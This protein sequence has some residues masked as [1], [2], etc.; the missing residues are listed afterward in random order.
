MTLLHLGHLDQSVEQHAPRAVYA[1]V[2]I[3]PPAASASDDHP[4][5]AQRTEVVADGA[6]RY[7]ERTR[8]LPYAA[9]AVDKTKYGKAAPIA[10]SL[11]D[12]HEVVDAHDRFLSIVSRNRKIR[13]ATAAPGYSRARARLSV[14]WPPTG[15]HTACAGLPG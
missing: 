15:P 7:P 8:H 4:C 10:E 1:L 13:V 3:A 2:E 14:R 5:E 11:S 6:G 12:S 9:P